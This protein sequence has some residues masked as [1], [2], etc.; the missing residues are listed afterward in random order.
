MKIPLIRKIPPIRNSGKRKNPGR[1]TPVAVSHHVD[2]LDLL[3][4][5]LRDLDLLDPLGDAVPFARPVRGDP[6]A[7]SGQDHHDQCDCSDPS[8]HLGPPC[9]A[10]CLNVGAEM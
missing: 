3:A 7:D 1:R 10:S 8:T 2:D 5:V 4:V 9:L 6:D